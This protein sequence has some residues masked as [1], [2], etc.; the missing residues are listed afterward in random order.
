MYN[1]RVDPLVTELIGII[2]KQPEPGIK[3]AT[4]TALERMLANKYSLL[5]SLI[6]S[7]LSSPSLLLSIYLFIFLFYVSIYLSDYPVSINLC[8]CPSRWLDDVCVC[9]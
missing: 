8:A 9:Y 3:A 7:L 5:S 1:K 6:S 2:R 4:F